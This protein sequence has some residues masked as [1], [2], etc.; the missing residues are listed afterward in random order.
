MI[1]ELAVATIIIAPAKYVWAIV[2]AKS[3]TF[4]WV[5]LEAAQVDMGLPRF[6]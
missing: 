2:A 3:G 1:V 6:V 4:W 5:A